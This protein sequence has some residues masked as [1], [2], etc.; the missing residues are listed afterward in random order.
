MKINRV[1][2]AVMIAAIATAFAAPAMADTVKLSNYVFTPAQ[3]LNVSVVAPAKT[4]N[5]GAG[6]FMGL[7]NGNSFQT[8]CTDLYQTFNWNTTYNYSVVDG[9]TAWGA[10]RSLSMDKLISA[11]L[12]SGVPTNAAQSA[13]VQAAIWEVLYETSGTYDLAAGNF[14]A[15]S[16]DGSTQSL[17]NT[18][19]WAGIAG[20]TVTHHVNQLYSATN[21]DFMVITAVPEPGTY[22]MLLAGLGLMGSV[23]RRRSRNA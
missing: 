14:K 17:L 18:V 10:T 19:N 15:T 9:V 16:S 23:A 7:L 4:Y 13:A 11:A 8:Y 6:Q 1:T 2:K 12:A 22:A 20:T 5:G 3:S 21:Q